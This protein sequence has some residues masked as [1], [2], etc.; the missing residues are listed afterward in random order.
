MKAPRGIPP[1]K[2]FARQTISGTTPYFCMANSSPVRPRPVWIS[3]KIS[4]VPRLV[5]TLAKRLEITRL[6]RTHTRLALYRFG[7]H[8]GRAAR[9]ALQLVE[10]VEFDGLHVGQQRPE[11]PLPLLTLGGA[12]HAHR[13]VGRTVVGRRM[14][15]ISVR[16]VKRLASFSAPSTASA[17]ELT[18]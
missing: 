15:I 13:T 8:A 4:S 6:R 11:G 10:V 5:A 3:S 14:E 12:H 16:P 2:A 9:D 1:P 18:K 17:P 7:Q